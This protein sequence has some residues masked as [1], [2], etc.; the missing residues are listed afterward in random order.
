MIGRLILAALALAGAAIPAAAEKR[1]ALAMHGEP[2][3]PG[4]YTHFPYANP[5][6]PKGG[7]VTY[8]VI[9]TFDNL[10]PFILKSMRTTARGVIDQEYGN[11]VFEPLMVRS[12]DEPFTVY[13]HLAEKVETDA[14]RTWVEFTLNE[15]ARWSD[16]KPVTPEDVI[17]TYETYA[18]KGR[19][20]Y[21]DRMKAIAR[22]EK[23]GERT[24]KFTLN[25]ES[26][27]EF[28][29]ILAIT[30]IIAKHATDAETFD[31]TTLVPMIGSGPYVVDK[32]APGA[33]ITFRRNPDYWAK[34]LPQKKGFDNYDTVAIEY[35][36]DDGAR[37]EAFKKGICHISPESNPG[38]WETG[39]DFPAVANGEVIKA[40]YRNGLPAP[41][42]GMV[43]NTRRPVFA[44]LKVRKALAMLYDFEWVNKNLYYD[45]YRRTGS[46]WQNSELSALTVPA[47]ETE[48]SLLGQYAGEVAPDVLDGTYRPTQTD[49]SGRD[50]QV[51]REALRLLGEAGFKL[52]GR[53]LV[54][55]DG[56]PLAFEYMTSE[57]NDKIALSYQRT[58]ER[59]GIAV[60]LRAVDE[61]QFQ[62]RR[63]TFEYDMMMANYSASL[64]P[65]IEQTGRWGSQSKDAEGSFNYA[66]VA[67]PAIDAA[68]RTIVSQR[69][70]APFVDAVRALD[71]LL[72]SG[73]YLI[74]T[75][76]NPEQWVAFWKQFK[77]P[78]KTALYGYQLATWW[79]ERP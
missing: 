60:T 14:E 31:K 57:S 70:R 7:A 10:N 68:I 12:A 1:H 20:P 78:E 47:G 59:L 19:P 27:R 8:C 22:I 29:L 28:P 61:T 4:T 39:Y 30:P 38:R 62:Q 11:L 71:R 34:D 36:R 21:K 3:L 55:K 6:A 56:K 76:H 72:I 65:G 49:G 79:R 77:Q 63:Q 50:R 23:T 45:K 26:N 18:A 33:R 67:S 74:P 52:D 25:A 15:K 73:H 37:L 43:F 9:G 5:G 58:L 51:L 2:A 17:F 46:Y 41:T 53:T 24:V 44:D 16:G 32:V 75:Q 42:I 48:K 40:A 69:D 54:G 35:F 13:G 64:S 66:G